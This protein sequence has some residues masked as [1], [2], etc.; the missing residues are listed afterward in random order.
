VK[1]VSGKDFCKVLERNGWTLKRIK[2]SHHI[3]GKPGHQ[4]II[5]VPV[6]KNNS[7]KK[8]LLNDLMKTAGLTEQDIQRSE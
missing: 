2:G 8:G 6:H 4:A 1:S 7:L 5:S 3:Y